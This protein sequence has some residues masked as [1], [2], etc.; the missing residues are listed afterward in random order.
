MM[1]THIQYQRA[2]KVNEFQP[3]ANV[4]A[5]CRESSV[6]NLRS[7]IESSPCFAPGS[8]TSR[9][10]M[11]CRKTHK[12][13]R[14]FEPLSRTITGANDAV[15]KSPTQ[16]LSPPL[17]LRKPNAAAP[18]LTVSRGRGCNERH[19]FPT[20]S[21]IQFLRNLAYAYVRLRAR[22]S[23]ASRRCFASTE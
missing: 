9:G 18:P 1:H 17:P 7:T 5:F 13:S 21:R 15:A 12:S 14:V 2:R 6:Y 19:V 4:T 10:K 16:P 20:F 23:R 22:G 11:F 8:S 3:V